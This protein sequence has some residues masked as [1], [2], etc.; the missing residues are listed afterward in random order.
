MKFN[1]I[2][3]LLFLVVVNSYGGDMSTIDPFLG[4]YILY[5]DNSKSCPAE[6]SLFKDCSLEG[7][8][9]RHA[10]NFDFSLVEINNIDK[11]KIQTFIDNKIIYEST[12]TLSEII[13]N[14]KVIANNYREFVTIHNDW[15]TGVKKIILKSNLLFF[16]QK[17]VWDKNPALTIVNYDCIYEK[18]DN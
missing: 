12:S 5:K 7:V 6:I 18:N 4:Q 14:S 10:S 13:N 1:K 17:H 11:G 16:F 8:S 15:R 9:L 2:F 3:S